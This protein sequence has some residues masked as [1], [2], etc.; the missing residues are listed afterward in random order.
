MLLSA[1]GVKIPGTAYQETKF[2]AEELLFDSDLDATVIRPSVIFGNP[3][4]RME[5]ATQLFNDMVRK[6]IPAVAFF[7]GFSPSRGAVNLS[8]VHVQDVARAVTSVLGDDSTCDKVLDLAG[9]E[10]IT[11]NTMIKRIGEATGRRKWIIP[12]PFSMMKL[13]A[14][15]L[16]WLPFFPVTVDQLKM[17]EEDN[18]AGP[19][20]IESLLGGPPRAFSVPQLDYLNTES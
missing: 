9:P 11:W 19:E 10:T 5:I 13:A 4:G 16:G 2:R 8:P 12:V 14:R 1:I 15:F 20:T 18:T 3:R 6:P 17:L 7:S